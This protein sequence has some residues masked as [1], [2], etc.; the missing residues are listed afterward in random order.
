MIKLQLFFNWQL[1]L[2]N[3]QGAIQDL[4]RNLEYQQYKYDVFNRILENAQD[5]AA[6]EDWQM[7]LDFT[8]A[9]IATIE[10]DLKTQRQEVTR[11]NTVLAVIKADLDAEGINPEDY[12]IADFIFDDFDDEPYDDAS[13]F[14]IPFDDD[15]V[16]F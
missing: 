2:F 7:Y 3:A 9:D 4:E 5:E 8:Q 13:I 1:T 12:D 10:E 15:D 11:C 14:G 6:R 16:P